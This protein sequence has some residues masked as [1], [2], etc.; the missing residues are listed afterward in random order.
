MKLFSCPYT[1]RKKKQSIQ[2]TA[3]D[4][5]R[6]VNALSGSHKHKQ[7]VTFASMCNQNLSSS[8]HKSFSE[9][10]PNFISLVCLGKTLTFRLSK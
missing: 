6:W 2:K 3:N 7:I 8:Y 4:F 10:S 1:N 9:I 5:K